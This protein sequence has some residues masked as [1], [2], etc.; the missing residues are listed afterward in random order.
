[1]RRIMVAMCVFFLL[2]PLV[3]LGVA[4]GERTFKAELSGKS[5]VPSV[6]TKAGGEM[7]LTL[8]KDGK[9]LKYKL[10]VKDIENVTAAHI[11][12][13]KKGENGPPV[14]GLFMGPEKA[15]KFSGVLA[16]GTVTGQSMMGGFKGKPLSSVIK[17]I[18]S[19]EAYVNVHTGKNPAGEIRGQIR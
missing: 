6:N 14:V 13:G 11:H 2:V 18:E 1:M 3:S 12:K 7:V 5:V 16:E 4:A 17:L 9:I 10:S 19:G 8:S 15:G